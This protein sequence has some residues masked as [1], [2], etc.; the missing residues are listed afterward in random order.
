[1]D[2]PVKAQVSAIV[3]RNMDGAVHPVRTVA[4]DV[5]INMVDVIRWPCNVLSVD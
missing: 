4:G 1:M 5:R 3:A 2:I